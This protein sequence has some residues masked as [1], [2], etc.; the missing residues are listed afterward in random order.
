VRRNK[1]SLFI[2]FVWATWDRLP[3]IT[4]RIERPLHRNIESEAIRQGCKVV[5]IN[6]IEYHVHVL[7]M[8]PSTI[9]VA[10]LVQQMKGVSLHFI[11][12][13][14]KSDTLFKW[15]GSYGAFSVSRHEVDR[16]VSYIQR[17][18]EHHCENSLWEE[19]EACHVEVSTDAISGDALHD[20]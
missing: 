1:L 3:L 7:L 6:G 18:K 10:V 17:Q 15:Q 16:V 13:V 2:H 11:N 8:M 12:D 19:L 5:A 9:S 14:H 4:P 20:S